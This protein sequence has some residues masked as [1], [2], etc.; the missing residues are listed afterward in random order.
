MK[1]HE[2]K[3]TV[4]NLER[5]HLHSST[6]FYTRGGRIRAI[7]IYRYSNIYIYL[8]LEISFVIKKVFYLSNL[9]LLDKKR[10]KP[11]IN[12]A[13]TLRWHTIKYDDAQSFLTSFPFVGDLPFY[14]L[15]PFF[16]FYYVS[17][18]SNYYNNEKVSFP[19]HLWKLTHHNPFY[20][21]RNDKKIQIIK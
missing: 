14:C 18:L 1:I 20:K 11:S 2:N 13:I 6:M 21:R 16:L 10:N 5:L 7:Y 9:L 15:T 3:M 8:F 12:F 17:C 19:F 4:K